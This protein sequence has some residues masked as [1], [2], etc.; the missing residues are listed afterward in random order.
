MLYHHS[1]QRIRDTRKCVS[2]FSAR[3]F[4]CTEPVA[5][6][7]L[8]VPDLTFGE[9]IEMDEHIFSYTGETQERCVFCWLDAP[10]SK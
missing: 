7:R 6:G 5:C 8:F 4:F 9:H 10:V 2:Y 1:H 3:R